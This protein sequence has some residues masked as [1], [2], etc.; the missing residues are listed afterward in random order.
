MDPGILAVAVA[1]A[2]M[3]LLLLGLITAFFDRKLATLTAKEALA[4]QQ[5][6]ERLRA[7]NRNASDIV[8]ILNREGVVTYEAS[9]AWRILG[10]RTNE[11][12][13]RP[14]A[15]FIPPEHA[16]EI[17]Q[18]LRQLLGDP[19][20]QATIELPARHADGTIRHFEMVGKNLLHDPAICGLVVNLRDITLRK[21]LMEELERLS[22]TDVLTNTFNRRGFIK[23][24]EPEFERM[25]RSGARPTL[26]MID[27]DHFKGVNDAYGHA[28]GDMVLAMMADRCRETIRNSDILARFGGEEFLILLEASPQEA[29]AIVARLQAA[30]AGCRVPTIKGDVSITASFGMATVDPASMDLET[31]DPPRR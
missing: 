13:G 24:A 18:Y 17:R 3:I 22:E 21:Q 2:T 9:S 16:F 30:I 5:S 11:M 28:A 20:G 25:R 6:E 12:V 4:L 7:L 26:V 19:A 8:A 1:S 29:H 23:L 27:I 10:Y 31:C 14:I 15:H